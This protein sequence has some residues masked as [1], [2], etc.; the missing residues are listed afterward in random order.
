MRWFNSITN[1]LNMNFNKFQEIVKDRETLRSVVHEVA[2]SRNF[3]KQSLLSS[4]LCMAPSSYP[5]DLW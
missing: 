3:S 5:S 1:S 2:E 4:S